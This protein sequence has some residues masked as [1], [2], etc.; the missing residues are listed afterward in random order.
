M[1]TQ[2]TK[3]FSRKIKARILF[4][5]VLAVIFACSP[6]GALD[7]Y[8]TPGSAEKAESDTG[9]TML[10]NDELFHCIVHLHPQGQ[11]C[12]VNVEDNGN[13]RNNKHVWLYS[14]GNSS[15]LFLWKAAGSENSYTIA[16]NKIDL[17]ESFELTDEMHEGVNGGF[18]LP[19][20][21][22]E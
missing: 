12:A 3:A 19:N 18:E 6:L 16:E 7:A 22:K 8:G 1:L 20:Y 9:G 13:G 17:F 10:S 4:A 21:H 5:V 2:D 15:R 14:I 11:I